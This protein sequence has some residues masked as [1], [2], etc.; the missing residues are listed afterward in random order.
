MLSDM[1]D[2]DRYPID[3]LDTERGKT[4][5]DRAQDALAER[6]CC[7]LPGFIRTEAVDRMQSEGEAVAADAYYRVETVNA[8]NIDPS[9]P[10]PDDHPARIQFQRGNAFV[11][12]DMIPEQHL[13]QQLYT[14][15]A[16]KRFVAA[17]FGLSTIHELTDPLAGLCL[18]VLQPG[19]SHPWHFDTN[20]FT[21]SLL[22]RS[23]EVGGRFEYCPGIRS[24]EDENFSGVREVLLGRADDRVQELDLQRGDLQLFMGRYSLHRVAEVQGE[25]DRHTAIFAYSEV[26]GVVGRP[27][28]T[29]QLFGR[30]SPQ[31]RAMRRVQV[32]SDSLMD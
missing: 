20:E 15:V 16:F 11:A 30:L 19:R 1:I 22:T 27:E 14:A 25:T 17:C 5:L 31:H 8:Y 10:L 21:V 24:P 32:R 4:L 13:I 3:A 6:G 12:R 7:V 2:L 9:Q 18:N 26:P 23:P 29:R 28:R